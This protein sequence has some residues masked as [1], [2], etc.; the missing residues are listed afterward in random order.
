MRLRGRWPLSK[1]GWRRVCKK[2]FRKTALGAHSR[3]DMDLVAWY[4]SIKLLHIALVVLSASLFIARALAGLVGGRGAAWAMTAPVRHS[5]VA[6]DTL[7]LCAG[8]SL[9]AIMRLNPLVDGWLG[10]KLL[11]LLIYVAL[12]S[13]ALKRAPTKPAKA[14]F[15]VAALSVLGTMAWTART[16]RVPF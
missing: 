6:I 13:M 9:W 2:L 10:S 15:L 5:S 11:L 14:L 3:G 7:L 12:G 8:A 4:P 1:P 16:H